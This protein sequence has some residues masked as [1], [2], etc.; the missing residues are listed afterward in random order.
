[1]RYRQLTR[2]QTLTLKACIESDPD[3]PVIVPV[4]P[5]SESVSAC[6]RPARPHRNQQRPALLRT[7]SV[8]AN[9]I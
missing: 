1:M 4:Q 2:T 5:S 7:L 3:G 6:H 9:Q 8:R